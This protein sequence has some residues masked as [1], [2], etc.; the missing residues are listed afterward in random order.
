[1]VNKI[2]QPFNSLGCAAAAALIA[3]ATPVAAQEVSPSAALTY[4][5]I[6]DLADASTMVIH[7]KIRRQVQVDR[8]RAPGLQ[9]GFARLFIEAQT[10]ALLSGNSAV[11][12]SLRYVVDVPVD[13][14]GRPP[15]LKKEEVLLFARPV[16][17]RPGEVQLAGPHAQQ[18]YTAE[19]EQ[20]VR[21]VLTQFAAP[22]TPPVITG[23]RDALSVAGNLVGESET[24]VFLETRDGSPVSLTIL[25]RPNRE[26]VWGVSWGEIIDQSARAPAANTL[27]WYRLAC[28]LPANLPSGAIL[29]RDPAERAQAE[30]DYAFVLGGLGPCVRARHAAPA[31]VPAA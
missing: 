20:R 12:E 29:S 24:Q 25:R 8:E 31:G 27:E 23:V 14:K 19:L 17:S 30:R 26:P 6:A 11:G 15:K 1:M 21:P 10:I 4:A 22:E 18:L 5:D 3:V 7:A 2:L 28:A 16:P 13:A 9:A